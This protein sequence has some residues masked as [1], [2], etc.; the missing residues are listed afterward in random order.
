[1]KKREPAM[2]PQDW[3]NNALRHSFA[4]Y[5]MALVANAAQFAEECG[6]GVQATNQHDRE[7]V[8]KAVAVGWLGLVP[9]RKR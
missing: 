6:H 5:R 2:N 1:M 9:R 7:L 8:T 4:S 3:P